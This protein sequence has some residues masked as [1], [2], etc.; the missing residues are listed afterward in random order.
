MSEPRRA[1]LYARY[2][3]DLQNEKSVDDQLALCRSYA[4]REGFKI[5]GEYHDAAKSGASMFGRDGL[6]DL[7]AAAYAGK[8][9][10][11][12]V[13]ALDRLSRDMEDLAGIHKRLTFAGIKILA[14]HDGGEASTAM[15]G[16]KATFAQ[17][18][19]EDGAKKVRRGMEGLL[20]AGKT[21]GG[22]A[23]GYA[24]DPASRGVPLIVEEEAAIV[25]RI[26]QEYHDGVSP[27]AICRALNAEG[28]PAPRGKLW[29]PGALYGFA[30][31][32]TG[33][34]RNSIYRGRIVWNKVRMIKDPDTGKRISRPNPKS[35]WLSA[36]APELE[37]VPPALFDAVQ[38]QLEARS[39][40]GA[41]VRQRRPV[42]LLSGLIKCGACGAGMSVAGVDKSGRTRLRCS[43][44]TNS[45]A[46]P[47]PLTFYLGD[48]EALVIDTLADEL[49]TE[50]Q[51]NSYARAWLEGRHKE[52]AKDMARR[53]KAETRLK[54]IA[55]E[56]DNI[57][58]LLMKGIGDEQALGA[59][60]KE[61][62]AER[63]R[64]KAELEKEPPASNIVVHPTAVAA[65]AKSLNTSRDYLHS[66]KAKREMTL[67]M[68]HDR[69]D[70][71]QLVREVV[72]SV[73]LSRDEDGRM[74][75]EVA[76]WLDHF[77]VEGGQLVGGCQNGSGGGT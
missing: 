20:A 69:G 62:G 36:D 51:V 35:E 68:L 54:A 75:A 30:E 2:S 61:L 33:M 73:T 74:C 16:L 23:Y 38:T 8:C 52:A 70:L 55:K 9:D 46:C 66:A 21:A 29:A 31:R 6:Q 3:T 22:R 67:H 56:L 40:P 25:L 71:H 60:S 42:R 47:D 63:D 65:F 41:P 26:F 53:A 19:R 57:T 48:V 39:N 5:V 17:M 77:T 12:I 28:I 37:I 50:E 4:K 58:R 13:E 11:V 49:A 45:G 10:A 64:L 7:L 34:L 59:A 72:A 44:H 76:T 15:I 18:F 14:V 43:A 27:K 24:P 1:V 32:G